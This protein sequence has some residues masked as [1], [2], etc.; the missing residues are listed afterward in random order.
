MQQTEPLD[1]TAL[2]Q[3]I[4]AAIQALPS[5]TTAKV[6]AL[7]REYSKHIARAA[8]E[9]VVAL[10]LRLLETP[11]FLT[12]FVA[13]ELVATHRGALR[14]LGASELEQL[15]RGIASWEAVDTFAC[16]LAGPAWREHQVPDS[17]IVGWAHSPDRWRR[18]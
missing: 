14:S 18:R 13:Y 17:L 16:Y 5:R 8:P 10:A 7:R 6:R 1:T 12:R 4:W 15:G 2:A 9:A 3:E 11:D